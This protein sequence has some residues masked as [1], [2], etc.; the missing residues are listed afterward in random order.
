MSSRGRVRILGTGVRAAFDVGRIVSAVVFSLVIAEELF[1][2]AILVSGSVDFTA[3]ISGTLM[4]G[5]VESEYF[6]SVPVISV[7]SGDLDMDMISHPTDF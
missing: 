2:L 4:S 6:V 3:L 7:V 1:E 5:V